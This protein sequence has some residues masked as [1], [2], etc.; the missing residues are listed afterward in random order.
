[1]AHGIRRADFREVAPTTEERDEWVKKNPRRKG[2]PY[3]AEHLPCG[4]RMWYSGIGIGAHLR[5]CKE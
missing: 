4:K 1:M 2:L 5:A 3:R